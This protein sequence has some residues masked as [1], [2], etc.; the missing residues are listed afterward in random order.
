[1]KVN[2]FF[3]DIAKNVSKRENFFSYEWDCIDI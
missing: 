3:I 1:M 2:T